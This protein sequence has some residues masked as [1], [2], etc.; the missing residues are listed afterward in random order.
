MTA[1]RGWNVK[2]AT[3]ST[4]PTDGGI[5]HSFTSEIVAAAPTERMPRRGGCSNTSAPG[6]DPAEYCRSPVD[7]KA[8]AGFPVIA[9]PIGAADVFV[10][11]G[12]SCEVE[13]AS[14][15]PNSPAAAAKYQ[16]TY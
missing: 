1:S 8:C 6:E 3:S 11:G 5:L 7:L 10:I 14:G 13:D 4:L 9:E 12:T 2:P 15:K 16:L